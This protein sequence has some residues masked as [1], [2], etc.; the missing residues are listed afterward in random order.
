MS[1]RR[2]YIDIINDIKNIYIKNNMNIEFCDNN[3]ELF[4]SQGDVAYA[5][6]YCNLKCIDCGVPKKTIYEHIRCFKGVRCNNCV[7]NAVKKKN[8]FSYDKLIARSKDAFKLKELKI[9]PD[10]ESYFNSQTIKPNNRLCRVKC[11]NCLDYVETPYV[12]LKCSQVWC[13]KCKSKKISKKLSYSYDELIN[14]IKAKSQE[15]QIALILSKDNLLK[16][17]NQESIVPTKRKCF[18]LCPCCEQEKQTG[19]M[20]LLSGSSF[21]CKMCVGSLNENIFAAILDDLI[22]KIS[23][24]CN[25]NDIEVFNKNNKRE[26]LISGKRI[27]PDCI[28]KYQEKVAIIEYHGRQ[29]YEAIDRWG[30]EEQFKSQ[31]ER[32]DL[33]FNYCKDNNIYYHQIDG[34]KVNYNKRSFVD[35]FKS[36]DYSKFLQEFFSNLEDL[37]S[38]INKYNFNRDLN[39]FIRHNKELYKKIVNS[40]F[41]DGLTESEIAKKFNVQKHFVNKVM[42]LYLDNY[43][44]LNLEIDFTREDYKRINRYNRRSRRMAQKDNSVT[45]L[46]YNKVV[47]ILNRLSLGELAADIAKLYGTTSETIYMIKTNKTWKHV[48]RKNI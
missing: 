21:F 38:I 14:L 20:Q 30:G 8:S 26:L 23:I 27:I 42:K 37:S 32:D 19:Y 12:S 45:K 46:N 10:N 11:P 4:S 41:N 5:D 17:N 25:I 3:E 15:N 1:K 39:V 16:F 6:K 48:P 40:Y 29:H 31:K 2:R 36:A 22:Q 33:L 47:D 28:I 34:R 18:H 44:N 43:I 24:N 13:K 7:I 35:Y 9:H